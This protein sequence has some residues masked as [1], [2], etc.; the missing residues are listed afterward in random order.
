M[1]LGPVTNNSSTQQTQQP[2][3]VAPTPKADESRSTDAQP[4]NTAT[5]AQRATPDAATQDAARQL[6]Q[7][8]EGQIKNK[9]Q[10]SL[11]GSWQ[12]AGTRRTRTTTGRR[13]VAQGAPVRGLGGDGGGSEMA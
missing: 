10:D 11:D 6:Q 9:I 3:A 7:G 13:R 2:R 1:S 8:T 5:E 12:E 4:T